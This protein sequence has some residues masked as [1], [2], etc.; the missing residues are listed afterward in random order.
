MAENVAEVELHNI[1]CRHPL[2]L[3]A[4]QFFSLLMAALAF[5]EGGRISRRRLQCNI[6][7]FH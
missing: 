3:T 1:N 2:P 5:R 7:D 6:L 4:P